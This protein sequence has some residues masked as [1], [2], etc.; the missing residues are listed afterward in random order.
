MALCSEG[1]S[2]PYR[3]RLQGPWALLPSQTTSFKPPR[4]S[5]LITAEP[6]AGHEER[7]ER[8]PCVALGSQTSGTTSEERL[9]LSEVLNG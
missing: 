3:R 7:S 5:S 1:E 6:G 2:R 4:V 9:E 8:A